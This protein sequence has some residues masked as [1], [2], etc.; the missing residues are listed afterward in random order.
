MSLSKENDFYVTGRVLIGGGGPNTGMTTIQELEGKEIPVWDKQTDQELIERVKAKAKAKAGEILRE[1]TK[2]AAKIKEAARKEG[3]NEGAAEASEEFANHRAQLADAMAQVLEQLKGQSQECWQQQRQDF[4]ALI[5][6]AV[7]KTLLVTLDAQ[8][9]ES[10]NNLL[11]QALETIDSLRSLTV[12]C[13]PQDEELLRTMMEIAQ[14][15]HPDLKA[16]QLRADP[17]MDPGGL[18]VESE[19]GMVDNSVNGRYEAVLQIFDHL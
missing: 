19:D 13:A 11:A 17:N 8:R 12:V 5:R 15:N 4:V 6:M 18:I 1:A 14:Q 7:E 16:W 10:L 9:E 2:E 3:F